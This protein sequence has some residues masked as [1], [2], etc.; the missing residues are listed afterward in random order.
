M[1]CH[2][3]WADVTLMLSDQLQGMPSPQHAGAALPR[4]QHAVVMTQPAIGW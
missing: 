1:S 3:V 2:D 4:P